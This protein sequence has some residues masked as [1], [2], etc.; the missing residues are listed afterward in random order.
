MA[1]HQQSSQCVTKAQFPHGGLQEHGCYW[2][3]IFP[4]WP[5]RLL[6]RV[7]GACKVVTL[8]LVGARGG[9][10]TAF[11]DHLQDQGSETAEQSYLI[12]LPMM[13]KAVLESTPGLPIFNLILSTSTLASAFPDASCFGNS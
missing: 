2:C 4:L 13:R 1:F 8:S 5:S 10:S 9:T 6:D 11:R 7:V 12:G 3:R